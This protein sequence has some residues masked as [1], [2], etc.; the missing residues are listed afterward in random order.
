MNCFNIRFN[1]ECKNIGE[2]NALCWRVLID[3]AEF[4]ASDIEI[5]V[6]TKTVSHIVAGI[7]KWSIYCESD[8]YYFDDNKKLIINKSKKNTALVIWMTG[9]SG[10]GKTT[11]AESVS[12]RLQAEGQ[13]TI[14]LDGD[15]IRSFFKTEFDKQSRIEHN[16][17]VGR[18]ASMLEKQGFI[19][20][21]SLISPY[22]KARDKCRGM[23]KTF[24]EIYVNTPIQICEMRDV[25]GLYA[26]ARA[27]EIRQFTGI[28]DA[29]EEPTHQ[30]LTINTSE[31]SIDECTDIIINK[32][33]KIKNI[34]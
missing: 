14:V 12:K 29:Y 1:T 25:K 26:K 28:D 15:D 22:A 5:N 2:E 9:L 8:N 18:M 32:L 30:E 23:A 16:L 7:K 34:K 33:L 13:K 31:K 6:Q 10:A 11:I 3:D 20:I 4:L 21:V 17:N 24:I 19:V 27:G